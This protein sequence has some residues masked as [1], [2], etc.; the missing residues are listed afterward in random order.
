[1]TTHINK[2]TNKKDKHIDEHKNLGKCAYIQNA[3]YNE[4]ITQIGRELHKYNKY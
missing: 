4:Q 3:K 2:I 1:M